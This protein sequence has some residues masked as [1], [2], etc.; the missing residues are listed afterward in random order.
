MRRVPA[1]SVRLRHKH[2]QAYT[3]DTHKHTRTHAR[4]R[5]KINRHCCVIYSLALR[6]SLPCVKTRTLVP[7]NTDTIHKDSDTNPKNSDTNP[8]HSDTNPKDSELT[9]KTRTQIPK[10]RTLTLKMIR[11]LTIFSYNSDK[12]ITYRN[13]RIYIYTDVCTQTS[14]LLL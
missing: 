5:H 9:L 2:T 3:Y 1:I 7:K 13:I 4:T 6:V 10:T 12:R 14:L 11:T 8:K